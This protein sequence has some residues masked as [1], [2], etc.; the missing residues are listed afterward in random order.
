MNMYVIR[1]LW[2]VGVVL[3]EFCA[4]SQESFASLGETAVA[5]NHKLS[6]TY[7]VNFAL[8]SRYFIL[9]NERFN[10][11]NRQLDIVHFSTFILDYRRSLSLGIQYRFRE[12]IDG[13]SDELRLTQQYNFTKR[14]LSIRY[15]HRI[16]LEQRLFDS[17]SILRTRYRFAMDFPLNGERLDVGEP[18]FVGTLE[19]LFSVSSNLK[20]EVDQRTT[21]HIGWL[22]SE[23]FKLQLG[24]EYRFEAFNIATEERLFAYT[25][26]IVKI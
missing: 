2:F 16:R 14:K 15:G 17:F 10:F 25:S 24:L 13:N 18:Y 23:S 4:F 11:S 26:A 21:V 6:D 5:L 12:I 7:N 9:Q 8:R 22:L 19:S 20:P 1:R 3:V